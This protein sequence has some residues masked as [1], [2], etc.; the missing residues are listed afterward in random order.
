MI[1]FVI[2]IIYIMSISDNLL[3]L[4]QKIP[5]HV[6][7]IAVSK[8]QSIQVIRDVYQAGQ[9]HFGENKVQE[10]LSKIP[11]LPD[12]IHWHFIGHLQRNK[13]KQIVPYV[14]LIHSLDSVRLFEEVGKEASNIQRIVPCLLQFHIATEETKFGF[15]SEEAHDFL[16]SSSFQRNTHVQLVGVM[17]MAS[18]TTDTQKIRTEFQNLSYIFNRIKAD[19]FK[20]EPSFKEISMGM[21]NDYEIA[22]EEGSTMLRL[23]TIVF[24]EHTNT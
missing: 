20:Q 5:S 10:L 19:F 16:K 22:I 21:S 18:F 14:H 11:Q 15:T 17:G 6:K 7:L 23:G 24:G 12:D 3:K 13:V 2:Q 4:R 1:T 9:T 8:T